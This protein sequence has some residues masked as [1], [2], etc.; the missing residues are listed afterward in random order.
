MPRRRV[1]TESRS[2]PVRLTAVTARAT[3]SFEAL[4]QRALLTAGGL[5]PAA[6][7][8]FLRYGM[9]R[10]DLSAQLDWSSSIASPAASPAAL[11]TTSESEPNISA[12]AADAVPLGFDSGEDAAVDVTGTIGAGDSDYFALQLN[13]G[14]ILGA[15][16]MAALVERVGGGVRFTG[17]GGRRMAELGLETEQAESQLLEGLEPPLRSHHC[18]RSQRL[19]RSSGGT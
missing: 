12:A 18:R 5:H 13:A 3:I 19:Y 15:N 17:I 16:L 7:T 2:G 4:E 14:D 8:A 6:M 9:S 1:A 11:I 10:A